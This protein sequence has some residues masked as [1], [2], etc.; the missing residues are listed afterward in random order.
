MNLD[1]NV[2]NFKNAENNTS[3]VLEGFTTLPI[4]LDVFTVNDILASMKVDN[5]KKLTIKRLVKR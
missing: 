2:Q 5:E 4:S 3:T 1:V